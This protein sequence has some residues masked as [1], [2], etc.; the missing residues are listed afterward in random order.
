MTAWTRRHTDSGSRFGL[1]GPMLAAVAG[2]M[3][4]FSCGPAEPAENALR[5]ESGDP[6]YADGVYRASGSV[7]AVDGWQPYLEAHIEAGAITQV[8][9]GALRS[10]GAFLADDEAYAEGFRIE[11]G[12]TL[13]RF[14][15][16]LESELVRSQRLPVT[17]RSTAIDSRLEWVSRFSAFADQVLRLARSGETTET[18]VVEPGLYIASD[19]ADETG[20]QAHLTL[21]IQG[22]QIAA[23]AYEETRKAADGTVRIRAEDQTIAA[24]Y[25]RIYGLRPGSVADE[26][27]AGYVGSSV[28]GD[29]EVDA[30]TSATVTTGRFVQLAEAI[31]GSRDVVPLPNRLCPR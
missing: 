30:I 5:S 20:W 13:N 11:T 26:I 6:L 25:E 7:V 9:F 24:D 21:A 12:V 27:A 31:L 28:V 1:A 8:C 3:L 4:L 18:V 29:V 10:D 17:V 14:L 23:A 16:D 22:E 2:A 15:R 19:R